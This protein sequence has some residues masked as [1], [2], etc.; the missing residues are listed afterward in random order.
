MNEGVDEEKDGW[1]KKY[2]IDGRHRVLQVNT[3]MNVTQPA[4]SGK[5]ERREESL[6]TL[7]WG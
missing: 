1:M 3:K 7:V 4:F 6:V 5:G 2:V